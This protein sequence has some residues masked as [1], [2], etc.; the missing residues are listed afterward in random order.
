[1]DEVVRSALEDDQLRA[2]KE[3]RKPLPDRGRAD[4]IRVS[5]QEE[6]GD[7]DL[8]DASAA[9]SEATSIPP[10][11]TESTRCR[12][13]SG[14]SSAAR[15]AMT[16]P[17]DCASSATGP[18]IS[19]TTRATR[20]SIPRTPGSCGAPPNPGQAMRCRAPG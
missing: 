20:S 13:R 8:T 11:V 1:E 6:P 14:F 17:I 9:P 5:P 16:P 7:H 10:D 4:R 18:V 12:T 15:T 2:R 3:L 19:R